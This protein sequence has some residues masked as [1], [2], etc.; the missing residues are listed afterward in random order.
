[1]SGQTFCTEGYFLGK[2]LLGQTMLGTKA[3]TG[4]QGAI[5]AVIKSDTAKEWV[6]ADP[7]S[8]VEKLGH[9]LTVVEAEHYRSAFQL[10]DSRLAALLLV[11]RHVGFDD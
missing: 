10:A 6:K 2:A 4:G 1:M 7:I 8:I 5:V 11:P 3:I 9:R